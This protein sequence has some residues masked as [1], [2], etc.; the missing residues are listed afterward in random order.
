MRLIWG[1]ISKIPAWLSEFFV[2]GQYWVKHQN[3]DFVL[4]GGWR[5]IAEVT[6]TIWKGLELK[7]SLRGFGFF[8][9]N[10]VIL[11]TLR[12]SLAGL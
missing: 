3:L 12:R 4:E 8:S 2:E 9:M 5:V 1:E 10:F 7:L 11:T 6:L